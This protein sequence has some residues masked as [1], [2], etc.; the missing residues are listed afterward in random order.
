LIKW[1]TYAG[2]F[3]C[4]GQLFYPF[5]D[6]YPTV[7]LKEKGARIMANFGDSPFWYTPKVATILH[8]P[9]YQYP[10]KGCRPKREMLNDDAPITQ[11]KQG[12]RLKAMPVND[13]FG[14]MQPLEQIR[15]APIP[16][17][18]A[19][20]SPRSTALYGYDSPTIAM[21]D[22][23]SPTTA[24]NDYD[25]PTAAMY[26]Y[27]SPATT[28]DLR[29]GDSG[30]HSGR[31]STISFIESSVTRVDRQRPAESTVQMPSRIFGV[32]NIVNSQ[33][34]SED[35]ED[36]NTYASV[37]VEKSITMN[38]LRPS[39]PGIPKSLKICKDWLTSGSCPR[40]DCRFAHDTSGHL[41][42]YVTPS[43]PVSL[44][45]SSFLAIG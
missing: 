39:T 4:G 44:A 11:P 31:P 30:R 14:M 13:K 40:A 10:R 16:R 3:E 41:C 32:Q 29:G 15:D 22:Y 24:M 33:E 38:E 9:S 20:T 8:Q 1:L 25:S 2:T 45:D 21:N 35:G 26:D 43:L 18:V 42:K 19:S 28:T 34:G 6:V 17:G 12:K 5:A 37:S 27:D 23:E 7:G 36:A